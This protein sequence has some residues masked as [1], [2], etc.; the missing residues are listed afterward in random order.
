MNINWNNFLKHK[1]RLLLCLFALPLAMFILLLQSN[2]AFSQSN[3]CNKLTQTLRSLDRNRDYRSYQKNYQSLQTL[4]K[5]L[6]QQESIFVRDG[7]QTLIKTKQKLTNQCRTIVRKILRGRSA[8]KDLKNKVGTGQMVAEQRKQILQQIASR[9]CNNNSRSNANVN[10][11]QNSEKPKTLFDIL[12]GNQGVDIKAEDDFGVPRD[13]NTVRTVCVR[14]CDGYFWPISFSTTT[15]YL[16]D[17]A[18]QCQVEGKG[19]EVQLFYYKNP[20]E[21][22]EDMVSI[23]GQPYS[24]M[25]NAFRY[26]NE[27]D[28]ACSIKK[29]INYGSIKLVNTE[30]NGQ[31]RMMISFNDNNF[32]MPLRD[33]RYVQ[34]VIIAKTISI[35]L[36]RP[37]PLREGEEAP[38]TQISTAPQHNKP[39]RTYTV[40]GKTIRI[41]GPDTPYAQL[42]AEGT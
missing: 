5:A 32:P 12:F 13:F 41:V 29:K 34:E 11:S 36:P 3:S 20:G 6:K 21:R 7:C 22:A 10:S 18:N 23:N 17:D 26:R 16:S 39:L 25:P 15:E 1:Y 19:A 2:I 30:L 33:P 35:T 9:G 27:Y 4:S 31:S 42:V 8:V 28:G 38:K 14:S 40:N 24:S 37:R